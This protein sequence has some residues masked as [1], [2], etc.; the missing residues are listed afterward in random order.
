MATQPTR[1]RRR[2]AHRKM[3]GSK[4]I[5]TL[6]FFSTG[7]NKWNKLS[8]QF[9][10]FNAS[11]VQ[12]QVTADDLHVG[13]PYRSGGPFKT[14]LLD[15]M[16]PY[17]V[18]GSGTYYSY[19]PGFAGMEKYTGGFAAPDAGLFGP[20]DNEISN[21]NAILTPWSS[22]FPSSAAY[23]NR[24]WASTVPKVEHANLFVTVREAKDIPRMLQGA[25]QNF[26]DIWKT[27]GGNPISV[28]MAP[29]KVADTFLNNQ[30]GWIP[31]VKDVVSLCDVS[32]RLNE[33]LQKMK[34]LNGQWHR[35]KARIHQ[36]SSEIR[37]NSGTGNLCSPSLGS[38]WF[39]ATPTWEVYESQK[40]IVYA[41]GMYRFY[42]EEFDAELRGYESALRKLQRLLTVYGLRVNPSNIWR[43]TPWTWLID[44]FLQIDNYIDRLQEYHVDSVAA[45]YLYLMHS[46]ERKL[47][48]RQVLP[49]GSGRLTL[50]FERNIRTK[51]RQEADSPY[52][53]DLS[54][55]NLSPRQLAIL[56]A[57]GITRKR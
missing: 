54:W 57:L 38:N 20:S 10:S 51:E 47:V 53:F 26:H 14:M 56:A 36:S 50:E 23:T 49:L 5:G 48:F 34:D 4:K 52:G 37:I 33:I 55:A 40:E 31:F 42:R 30:F 16:S 12:A 21:L 7:N 29:K 25:S 45:K 6:Y 44:W 41:A 1:I 2:I 24:A 32:I 28:L 3:S 19:Q 43:S 22:I 39:T 11:Y 15:W 46:K 17:G 9:H 27:M 13:P 18:V 8:D 35:R